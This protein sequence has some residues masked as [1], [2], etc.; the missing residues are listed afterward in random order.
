MLRSVG[1]DT[2]GQFKCE[3]S[4]EAPLFQTASRDEILAVVGKKIF[5]SL[6]LSP[7]S[8]TLKK[9]VEPVVLTNYQ[10]FSK[11]AK[12]NLSVRKGGLPSITT[13]NDL[14]IVAKWVRPQYAVRCKSTG[15]RAMF[16]A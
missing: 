7:F 9:G 8:L 1:L 3:V 10:S 2:T 13:F 6:F 11:R 12:E 15:S 16:L 4:G 5:P 14:L